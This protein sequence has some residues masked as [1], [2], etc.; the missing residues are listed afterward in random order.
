M[1]V[2]N[3]R[4]AGEAHILI[5]PIQHVR[6]IESLKAENLPMRK[7]DRPTDTSID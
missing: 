7:L 2:E 1:A 6:D 4:L 3:I 5:I